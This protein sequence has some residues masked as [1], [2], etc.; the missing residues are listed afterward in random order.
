MLDQCVNCKLVQLRHTVDP[1]ILYGEHYWYQSGLNPKLKQNLLDIAEFVN[2]LSSPG[3]VVLDIGANDGTLLSGIDNDRYKIACEPAPNLQA[4]LANHADHIGI[5]IVGLVTDAKVPAGERARELD[6]PVTV[7]PFLED[8]IKWDQNLATELSRLKPALIV[9]AGFMKI[10]GPVVLRFHQGKIINTHP[11]LLPDFPGA[12]AVR[13]ALAAGVSETGAT[14]H[15][16]DKG[17]DTGEVIAQVRVKVEPGD[18]EGSLHERI[19]QA[20]RDLLV[21]TV[22]DIAQGKVTLK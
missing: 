7:V 8:R 14:I 9:S 20:E 10:L 16:V 6:L 4:K 18:T 19:K 3:D 2:Q 17:I 22:R 21:A 1:N 11:A 12:H 15:F 13:D 5:Q